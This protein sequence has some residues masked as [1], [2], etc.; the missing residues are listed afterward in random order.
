VQLRYLLDQPTRFREAG[1]LMQLWKRTRYQFGCLVRKK[2]SKGPDVWVMRYRERDANGNA[3]QRSVIIGTVEQYPRK[4]HALKAAE[5]HRLT[6]NPDNPAAMGVSFA[7]L[8]DRYITQELPERYSTRRCYLCWLNKYIK[9]KWGEYRINDVKAFAVEEWLKTHD[10]A[11]K[12]KAHIR[13]IMHVLFD[14]AMRWELVELASN[15]M[16]LVR[17]KNSSK[18]MREPKIITP[19]EF[20]DILKHLSEPHI[21]MCKVAMCLGLRVSEIFALQWQ[22]FDWDSLHVLVQRAIVQGRVGDVKTQYSRKRMPIDPALAK[23]LIDYK[24]QFA[25]SAK[26]TDWVFAKPDTGKPPLPYH[27]QERVIAPAGEAAGVGRIG[28]HTFRHSYSTLLRSM[29]V[30]VKVQ[31]ELLRHANVTTTL[32]IYT[33]AVPGDVR[34]ANSKAVGMLL[35]ATA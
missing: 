29:N 34:E 10:L 31:Q 3:I 6:A 12:S 8:A 26:P 17:V 32:N 1:A 19:R 33:Q 27:I 15:P 23:A 14:A 2:R 18:R 30:D 22:D 4:A 13:S 7:S 21:T 24:R 25:Q 5:Q 11:P 20:Q 16:R 28:W 9:P 35:S